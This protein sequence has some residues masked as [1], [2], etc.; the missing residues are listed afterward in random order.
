MT[1]VSTRPSKYAPKK[2]DDQSVRATMRSTVKP[3]SR[4]PKVPKSRYVP[5]PS[6]IR[7]L[8]SYFRASRVWS[9][10]MDISPGDS[11]H[12]CVPM[13]IDDT[14]SLDDLIAKVLLDPVCL[15]NDTVGSSYGD[16][17]VSPGM[18]SSSSTRAV[19]S[20]AR[21]SVNSINPASDSNGRHRG[22]VHRNYRTDAAHVADSGT[23][24]GRS[25]GR[26]PVRGGTGG[27]G[28]GG[29]DSSSSDTS[30]SDVPPA[31]MSSSP[32]PVADVRD[33]DVHASESNVT[34]FDSSA[35]GRLPFAAVICDVGF[36]Y[37]LIKGK[38]VD[39]VRGSV[40]Y[41]QHVLPSRS[42][43]CSY[44]DAMLYSWE[45]DAKKCC[46]NGK[47]VHVADEDDP[48]L[49]VDLFSGNHPLSEHVQGI[50]ATALLSAGV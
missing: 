42:T 46:F 25:H 40:T 8:R 41:G 45:V 16:E 14:G 6:G 33:D 22:N 19:L 12:R 32:P 36:A 17:N 35:G 31:V 50:K 27:A 5:S 4:F 21:D 34:D 24:L 44:C 29:D 48:K 38:Y 15:T 26:R 13:D 30:H 2:F 3:L 18:R 9:Y 11:S 10:F 7:Y 1:G 20:F 28:G 47:I 37:A 39:C 23:D 43:V 49:L